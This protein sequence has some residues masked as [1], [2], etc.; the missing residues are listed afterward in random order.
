[1][2]YRINVDRLGELLAESRVSQNHW[3]LR[4][5]LSRGH[6][7]DLVNGK[8]PYPSTKTREALLELFGA[9]AHD[10]FVPDSGSRASEGDFR[11][12]ISGR[13]E[14]TR[15]LGQGGMGTV[16]LANDLS[17]KRLVALKAVSAE[18]AAGV[19]A[20]ELLKEIRVTARL[21][22]PCILP[23]FDAGLGAKSP[24]YVMPYVRGGSLGARLKSCGRLPIAEV[25]ALVQ[26]LAGGLGHA[27]A[28]RV[29]HCDIKPENILLDGDHPYLMDFGIARKLHS[30]ANEWIGIRRELDFSAGTPAYVSPEQVAGNTQ[31]DARSDVYSLACVVYHLLGGR[32]PFEGHSTQEIVS[33]RFREPA[34][35]LHDLAPDLPMPI[36]QAVAR[37]MAFEP[38]DRPE[39]AEQF[40]EELAV[41]ARSIRSTRVAVRSALTLGITRVARRVRTAVVGAPVPAQPRG[42]AHRVDSL[43]QDLLFALRRRRRTPVLT[44]TALL[45]LALGLGLATA[46]F[47]LVYNVLLRPLAFPEQDRLVAL[48]SVDSLGNAFFLTSSANWHDWRTENTSLRDVAIYNGSRMTLMANRQSRRV[49][50]VTAS[51]NLPQVLGMRLVFG[52][53]FDSTAVATFEGGV[54]VSETLWRD[55]LGSSR[56]PA[57]TVTL[58]GRRQPVIGVVARGQ[59][60]PEGTD[61]WTAYTHRQV[62]GA[63]RNNVN[64]SAVGRLRDDESLE[65]ARADL[66]AIARRIRADDPVALYSYGVGVVPL[67]EQLTGD[68]GELLALLSG[69]VGV[70]LLIACANLASANLAQGAARQREMAVRSALGAG[71]A[72]LVRQV[73]VEHTALA[74]V[75]GALGVGLAWALIRGTVLLTA[76]NLPRITDVQINVPVLAAA[77]GLSLLAGVLTGILPALQ[78]SRYMPNE[79]IGSAPR[80]A[81]GGRGL[82]GRV[83][84]ALEVAMAVMLVTG[85]GLLVRSFRNVLARPLGFETAQVA[86]AE[87]TLSADRYTSDSAAALN[88]WSRLASAMREA[89]GMRGAALAASV[90]LV[91]GG[92]GFIEVD[93]VYAPGADA[94]YRIVSEGYFE[95]LGIS[96]LRGRDFSTADA[97]TSERVAVVN[98]QMAAR[99]WPNESPLGKRIRATSMEPANAGRQASWITV[100]GVVSNT[101]HFGH[102]DQYDSEM[103]VLYRQLPV[104]RLQSLTAMARGSGTDEALLRTLRD[105]VARVDPEIPADF[106]LLSQ[107]AERS[108]AA[109]RFAMRVLE[110]FGALSLLLAGIGVYGVLSFSVAQRTREIAVRAALGADPRALFRMVWASGAMVVAAGL[111][112]G[113]IGVTGAGR[114]VEALLYSV[115]AR[116]PLSMVL[117]A[118]A[119]AAVGAIATIVPALRATRIDPMVALRED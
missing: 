71:R 62:G 39:G 56:D 33:R 79:V 60:F 23:V 49:S 59:E 8:H 65:R 96:F 119:I 72:R 107:A 52:H 58:D 3:A 1:M 109:R 61:L 97:A 38:G 88:Y 94:G 20:E 91:S 57:L 86:T 73:L 111:L 116:D 44:A 9:R 68:S 24:F 63:A 6:W 17:L 77:F 112:M 54:L 84:V 110:V 85:A 46:M 100:I 64:W 15:E 31:L 19:G 25:V 104:W 40:G 34:L 48:Q 28:Q 14:I 118:A 4:L 90:P 45:T 12:A 115:S 67:V 87:I 29:L 2:R 70:L 32:P 47:A 98:A 5:G 113:A 108:V 37:G 43:R 105:V 82:P 7:S 36:A 18:A 55:A 11:I 92:K 78:A 27:H 69:A 106:G 101:R 114:L 80:T 10:L 93:G 13:F 51:P 74:L 89:P 83:L 76:S 103:F 81:L 117:A 21:Q 30:E 95:M 102:E 53:S 16:F 26:R 41:A 75:G 99:Y 50:G 66:S 42:F 22:H 35:P